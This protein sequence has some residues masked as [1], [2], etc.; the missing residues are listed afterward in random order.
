VPDAPVAGSVPSAAGAATP[1]RFPVLVYFDGWPED[2][3]NNTNLIVELVSHGFA[4]ASVQYPA[5]APGMTVAAEALLRAQLARQIVGYRSDT[6]FERSV[7]LNHARNRVHAQDAIAVLNAL[8]SLDADRSSRFANRLDTQRA[9]TF[10]FSFGGGIAAEAS[11]LD[12]RIRAVFN[13]DGRHWGEALYK[14]VERP[15]MLITEELPMPTA[16]DLA[17]PIGMIRYEAKLDAIDFPNLEANLRAWGGIHIKV[18]GTAHMN[19]T[20]VPLRSPLRRLSEG[21][22]IDARRAQRIIQT[23]AVEFFSRYLLATRSPALDSS[24]PRFPEAHLEVWPAPR[25]AGT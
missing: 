3:I 23:Y 25:Q 5:K 21:G 20:D 8:A 16:A 24:W 13:M 22:S 9:G 6:D 18:A 12:P 2:T 1:T 15:Y 10:G 4:V 14:G 7:R 19:F 11:R 17:S